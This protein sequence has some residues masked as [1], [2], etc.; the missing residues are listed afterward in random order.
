[1]CGLPGFIQFLVSFGTM[2][3]RSESIDINADVK[4]LS[5]DGKKIIYVFSYT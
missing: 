3:N 4:H 1:M 5:L 2:R